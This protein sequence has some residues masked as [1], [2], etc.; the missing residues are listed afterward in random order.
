MFS[1]EEKKFIA[2]EVEKLLLGLKH[3][4]MPSEKPMFTLNV[5][6]KDTWSWAAIKPN[7]TFGVDNQPGVNPCNEVAR[8]VMKKG[9]GK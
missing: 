5:I 8:D 4:E 7:H 9:E 1:V 3:P 6:G 2:A